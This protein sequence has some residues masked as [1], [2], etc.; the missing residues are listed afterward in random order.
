[1]GSFHR[2]YRGDGG[3]TIVESLVASVVAIMIITA[4]GSAMAASFRGSRVNAVAQE[5]TALAVERLEFGRSLTWNEIAMS[6]IVAGAPML[7]SDGLHLDGASAGV[8][9]DEALVVD[10]GGLVPAQ[11]TESVDTTTY[12]IWQYVTDA[13]GGLRRL[14]ALVVWSV[15]GAS[16]SYQ[17]STLIAEAATR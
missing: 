8:P 10:P 7:S 14:V 6:A 13:G 12:S 16:Y 15:D 2:V 1:M 17:A 4:V 9:S 3:F 5:A 11:S